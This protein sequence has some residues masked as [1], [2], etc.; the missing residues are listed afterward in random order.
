MAIP[1]PELVIGSVSSL[2]QVFAV[3]FAA[4][5]GA[6]ALV[7]KRLGIQPASVG[8]ASG[9][10]RRAVAVLAL[11]TLGLGALNIWQFN[12]QRSAELNR[13][14][15]TLTRPAQGSGAKILDANLKET[16]F[17]KQNNS[18]LAMTTAQA[19]SL[20]TSDSGKDTLFFDVRETGE[21]KMGTLPGA[22][23]VR[24][25]DFLNADMALEGKQVVLFCHNGNRSSE[26][27]AELAARGIDC[28]F[29]AGGI[30][31]WIVEGRAF[32]DLNVKSLSDLR[33]LPDYPNKNVLLNTKQFTKLIN[34][35]IQIVDTRYPGDFESG[36]LPGAINIPL[37]ALPTAELQQRIAAL[38]DKP[39]V[40][41]CYD[42]RSCFMAQ[43]LGLEMSDAGIEFLGRYTTPWD[44]FEAPPVKPHVEEWLAAQSMGPW[45]SAI[46]GLAAALAWV[47]KHSHLV[48]GLFAL[49][50]ASRLMVLPIAL[51]SERDQ[52]TTARHA[53]ELAALKESLRDDPTRRA[54]AVQQFYAD[55]GL[56]P[57]RNMMALLFLPLMMLG[58]SATQQASTQ[59]GGSF[60]WIRDLGV[61]DPLFAAPL[62][63]T[64]LACVYLHWA[65]AKTKR[66]AILWWALGGPAMFA[67]VFQLA[68]AGNVYLCFSL[69]LLLLQRAYVTG[70]FSGLSA[71][72]KPVLERLR[73]RGDIHGVFPLHRTDALSQ[74]GNKSYRL[75]IM[76]NAGLPVPDGLVVRT[77]AVE[78]YSNMST[79]QKEQFSD[80]VWRM[81]EQPCAVRSSAAG[82][83]GEDQSFA[84]VFDSV[85]NVQGDAM[86]PALDAVVDSFSSARAQSY[87]TDTE[88]GHDGNILIQQM[89]SAEYAGVLFTKDPAAPGLMMVEMVQG[90]GD[91]LVSGR[92]TPQSLRFGR[93]TL[94][95]ADDETPPVD[96]TPL[97]QMARQIEAIFGRPQDIEWAY[98]DGAFKLL[99][100]RDI[101][102][103]GQGSPAE[104]ARINEWERILAAYADHPSDTVVLEQDEMAELL[105]C[106]TPLSFSLM[107]SLWAPGGSLDMAC[108]QLRLEY[109]LPEGRP[110]HLVNLFGSTYVDRQLKEKMALRLNSAKAR[111]LHREALSTL[112]RFR[113]EVVPELHETMAVWRAIDFGAL[114]AHQILVSIAKLRKKLLREAYVEAEKINILASFTM[115]EAEQATKDDPD[116]RKRLMNPVLPHAPL[117]QI[118]ACAT[119]KGEAQQRALMNLMGHRAIFDYELSEPRYAEA[120]EL[121]APML[122]TAATAPEVH[123][124][125]TQIDPHDPVSLAIAF[126]DLKEHAKH[127]VLHLVALL[128]HATLALAEK[129]GMD[130]LIF[131]LT[132][133]ELLCLD[134][135][136]TTALHAKAEARRA[137][138]LSLLPHAI[139]QVSLTLHDIERLSAP[140]N[141]RGGGSAEGLGGTC[142]SGDAPS[143]GR[144]FV[145]DETAQTTAQAFEG[146]QD[147]DVIVCRMINPAWL[148]YL[149]RSNGVLSEVGG[150]L[151]HMAILAREKGIPMLVR[152]SGLESLET[153]QRVRLD[154]DGTIELVA[155]QTTRLKSA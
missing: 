15:A 71:Q 76:K 102:T 34:T 3:G 88:N 155:E 67:L 109:N 9:L 134:L 132:M 119:L 93:Y 149:Q 143:K 110:G 70:H 118:N 74:S 44:Y 51:K 11:L 36:H 98:A 29:I 20:L 45:Q 24:Y 60:L 82:E 69:G 75:S 142:V 92:V 35:D 94:T 91:D 42:R 50:L 95:A 10:W 58:L 133:D 33:A 53:D 77:E 151:S 56:T 27:C 79:P 135:A 100:S 146:F 83:D 121:L 32:S 108:R 130:D 115:T 127:E 2:S 43:V 106:P 89:V 7:A 68:A 147:G 39:T 59:L 19:Q 96:L 64:L 73:E 105:P 14:Q 66:Q 128:R 150:W 25:P 136:D 99:Q 4:V 28:R 49:S 48:V 140:E 23:H 129:T 21:N 40:A 90:C 57:M 131:Y 116:A 153:G 137:Q 38:A 12:T 148:P 103:L 145:A 126:Q 37:R 114:P 17:S 138:A 55:K 107:A 101:T 72:F 46:D 124:M 26:T 152:C 52:L 139:R 54:R 87:D 80:Q 123:A 113:Q 18:P 84:G 62:I 86:R 78:A 31:K 61:P 6:G 13:L 122:E 111:Q 30:E 22:E 47:A 154:P 117:N 120:P 63:F 5:T 16:S 85:L 81:I 112:H 144:V 125:D 104:Q 41:A 97:L 8:K 1:S 65:M 141:L